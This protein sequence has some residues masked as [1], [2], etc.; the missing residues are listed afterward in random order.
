MAK[1]DMG[2]HYGAM[3]DEGAEDT[4]P[5][6]PKADEGGETALLPKSFFE[7]KELK[8][9]QQYYVEV[10]RE[11]EDEVEVKYPHDVKEKPT[12]EADTELEGMA[13]DNPGNPGGGMGGY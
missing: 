3:E 2:G 10:V 1:N 8:P 13:T 12:A 6:K 11:Y 9:G 4:A 7:G 5:S